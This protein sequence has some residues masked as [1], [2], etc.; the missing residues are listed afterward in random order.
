MVSSRA[1]LQLLALLLVGPVLLLAPTDAVSSEVSHRRF[2]MARTEQL[3]AG[4]SS[5]KEST[6]DEHGTATNVTPA[7][8]GAEHMSA[9][10]LDCTSYTTEAACNQ[11][12]QCKWL[13][14]PDMCL[15]TVPP[16]PLPPLS[17][18]VP[19][20]LL[21]NGV[22]MPAIACGTGGEDN[23]SAQV[24]VGAALTA[25]FTHIDTAHDYHDQ[26]G[27]GEAIRAFTGIGPFAP[28]HLFLTSK[29]PG[30]GV[31]TQGLMPP[32]YNNTLQAVSDDLAVLNYTSS[33]S[34]SAGVDLML[35]HFPPLLGC[36]DA[37]CAHMQQQWAA[38]EVSVRV[39][40]ASRGIF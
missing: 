16:P 33:T 26:A 36:V 17:R 1:L 32:C 12:A 15:P 31:P 38:L 3:R 40:D 22:R 13:A 20:L 18:S 10:R 25:G 4:W 23:S 34:T 14:G 6:R 8:L 37:N 2:R 19:T 7:A 5:H 21:H 27:V 30:C 35:V 29:V 39:A 28:E 24:T 11:H 9:V